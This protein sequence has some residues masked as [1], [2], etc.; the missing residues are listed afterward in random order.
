MGVSARPWGKTDEGVLSDTVSNATGLQ[1]I[2][3]PTDPFGRTCAQGAYP[4]AFMGEQIPV[5]TTW[6]GL[7]QT[8]QDWPRLS[9]DAPG[10]L[11]V[12]LHRKPV[13]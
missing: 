5:I 7:R 10:G 13:S 9:N 1:G 2:V 4:G 8:A 12:V 6:R 3:V 11:T